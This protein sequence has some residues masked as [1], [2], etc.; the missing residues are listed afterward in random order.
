MQEIKINSK[1]T[2]IR[3]VDEEDKELGILSFYPSDFDF[4]VR[5][6]QGHEELEKLIR[7]AQEQAAK[8]SQKEFFT[9]MHDLDKQAKEIL[10]R[11]FNDDISKLFGNTN[12]FTP[13]SDGKMLVENIL[14]S[15]IPVITEEINKNVEKAQSRTKKYLE[16]YE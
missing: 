9:V 1:K 2:S 7:E 12:M 16:G 10:N 3:I 4:P 8:L 14:D 6:E 5:V 15:I 13:L 11:I